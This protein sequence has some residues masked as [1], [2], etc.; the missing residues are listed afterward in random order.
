VNAHQKVVFKVLGFGLL[1]VFFFLFH[2]WLRTRVVTLGY[3]VSVER[4]RLR[5]LESEMAGAKVL[6][7][8]RM[9]PDSLERFVKVR[10]SQGEIL[11]PPKPDQLHYAKP[12]QGAR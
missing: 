2:I 6:R 10:E 11:A 3:E 8:R 12:P 5:A 4:E 1:C 9:G 7:A